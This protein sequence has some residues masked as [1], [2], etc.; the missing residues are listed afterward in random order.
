MESLDLDSVSVPVKLL[1]QTLQS[2]QQP[3]DGGQVSPTVLIGQFLLHQHHRL[4]HI[5]QRA[6][7]LQRLH[8]NPLWLLDTVKMSFFWS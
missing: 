4:L 1:L 6:L 5:I 3:V 2:F 8:E 7:E